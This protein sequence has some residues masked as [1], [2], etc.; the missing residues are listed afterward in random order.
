MRGRKPKPTA[1]KLLT[2][3]PGHRKIDFAHEPQVAAAIP[4]C[5]KWLVGEGRREWFRL[6]PLLHRAKL[7]TELD[8]GTLVQAC[9]AWARYCAA[10]Q[11]LAVLEAQHADL[12]AQLETLKPDTSDY[13]ETERKAN[14]VW[15]YICTETGK[16]KNSV[17]E[18]QK[19]TATLGMS[20][21]SRSGIKVTDGQ[22]ELPLGQ[23]ENAFDRVGRLAGA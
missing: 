22:G 1:L 9:S 5:P 23:P 14:K 21:Q 13:A 6:A 10:E 12:L 20:P 16:R 11:R 8:R 4:S 19:L 18:H 2:G 17:A 15:G 7:L 3:N